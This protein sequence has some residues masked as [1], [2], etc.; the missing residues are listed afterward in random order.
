MSDYLEVAHSPAPWIF[1]FAVMLV[2]CVQAV[3]F[4]R[5]ARDNAKQGYATNREMMTAMRVGGI[6][7]IGPSIAVAIVALSL[8]PVFGTPVVL[9]RIGMIGSVPYELAAAN[10][11]SETLGCLSAVRVSMVSHLPPYFH[12]GSW[13]RCLDAS[14]ILATSSMGKITE[15]VSL[16][17]LGNYGL[18]WWSASWCLWLSNREP[19]CGRNELHHRTA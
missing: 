10:A 9:M 12:Y 7:A 5:L 15:R 2:I 19:S 3:I 18:N 4:F 16:E 13:C 8:I 14:V 17:T 6:S 1:A 11:A